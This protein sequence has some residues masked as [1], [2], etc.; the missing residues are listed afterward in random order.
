[1]RSRHQSNCCREVP[2]PPSRQIQPHAEF[3]QRDI[4]VPNRL[5]PSLARTRSEAARQTPATHERWIRGRR[6]RNKLQRRTAFRVSRNSLFCVSF[7]AQ[8]LR[9]IRTPKA[10]TNKMLNQRLHGHIGLLTSGLSPVWRTPIQK[11]FGRP[12]L[13]TRAGSADGQETHFNEEL[14]S[15]HRQI[16]CLVNDESEANRSQT[17]QKRGKRTTK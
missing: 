16:V 12:H 9:S 6:T 4:D 11:L 17:R 14:P 1:M 5:R 8:P 13:P 15:V 2:L 3:W 10:R 7:G